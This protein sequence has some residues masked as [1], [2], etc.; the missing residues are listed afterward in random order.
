MAKHVFPQLLFFFTWYNVRTLHNNMLSIFFIYFL[1]LLWLFTHIRL[2][3][4]VAF[5]H[6]TT[7]KCTITLTPSTQTQEQDLGVHT[8]TPRN[9]H[10]H[11]HT[12][13]GNFCLQFCFGL[14]FRLANA[15]RRV[16]AFCGTVD[17][18]SSATTVCKNSFGQNQKL[19]G[20]QM[21]EKV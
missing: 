11:T 5:L 6:F 2:H 13:S 18:E 4:F 8:N 17:V 14:L 15:T 1:L 20:Y 9:T 16:K 12:R 7:L 10:T 19:K 21:S 3:I